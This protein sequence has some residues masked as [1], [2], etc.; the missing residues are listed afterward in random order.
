MIPPSYSN[1]SRASPSASSNSEIRTQYPP[2]AFLQFPHAQLLF[3]PGS[4]PS[5]QAGAAMVNKAI[6][7]MFAWLNGV[8]GPEAK[9]ITVN[10]VDGQLDMAARTAEPQ[11]VGLDV[12]LQSRDDAWMNFLDG[13]Q[14]LVQDVPVSG[15][16]LTTLARTLPPL[17]ETVPA[18]KFPQISEQKERMKQR[19]ASLILSMGDGTCTIDKK[20]LQNSK[21]VAEIVSQ[22]Q[23]AFEVE[24][25]HALYEC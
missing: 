6:G 21:E 5:W 25:L 22:L 14:G 12:Y 7:S 16:T 23:S 17:R 18:E 9:N 15:R 2:T 13:V 3:Y 10:L 1:H 11:D 20:A 24:T 4:G 19:M 8:A